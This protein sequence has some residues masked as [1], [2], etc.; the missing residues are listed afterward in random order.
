[1]DMRYWIPAGAVSPDEEKETDF[2]T[3]ETQRTQSQADMRYWILAGVTSHSQE[4]RTAEA[5]K[6][7][8][9]TVTK[10]ANDGPKSPK[11]PNNDRVAFD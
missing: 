9:K 3:D 1:M 4:Q 6:V 2:L 10:I 5:T 7:D 11:R 8:R